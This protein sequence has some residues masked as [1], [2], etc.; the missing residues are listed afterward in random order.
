MDEVEQFY[1]LEVGG[2]VGRDMIL[3]RPFTVREILRASRRRRRRVLWILIG[4]E[5]DMASM[6]VGPAV[7]ERLAQAGGWEIFARSDIAKAAPLW[8][9][10]TRKVRRDKRVWWLHN[11]TGDSFITQKA[12]RPWISEMAWCLLRRERRVVA[13]REQ[14]RGQMHAGSKPWNEKSA[15]SFVIHYGLMMRQGTSYEWD[16]HFEYAKSGNE[17]DKLKC[18]KA[19]QKRVV[20]GVRFVSRR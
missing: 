3:R 20:P 13:Q 15:N 1:T 8:F 17:K 11:G 7:R 19:K 10:Y 6:F 12:P 16:K 4:R 14:R 2:E 18:G 9:E 5:N